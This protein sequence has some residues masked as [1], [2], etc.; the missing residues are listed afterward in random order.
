MD[1]RSAGQATGAA[2]GGLIVFL[3]IL[4]CIQIMKRERTSSLCVSALLLF[5]I[6]WMLS[7]V[8][9]TGMAVWSWSPMIIGLLGLLLAG[10]ALIGLILGI[11]GLVQYDRARYDQ[12]RKQAV[13]GI[14]LC[15]LMLIVFVGSALSGMMKARDRGIASLGVAKREEVPDKNFAITPPNGW[16]KIDHTVMGVAGAAAGF[17]HIAPEMYCV[18]L[19][20]EF[21]DGTPI[22]TFTKMVKQNMAIGGDVREQEENDRT[23]ND[24]QFH[25]IQSILRLKTMNMELYYEHWLATYRGMFWQVMV[26]GD[27]GQKDA[28]KVA[29]RELIDQFEVL[30]RNRRATALGT[31]EDV[32]LPLYGVKTQLAGKGWNKSSGDL[33][34][35]PLFRITAERLSEAFVVLPLRFEDESPELAAIAAGTLATMEFPYPLNGQAVEKPFSSSLGEGIEIETDRQ[36]DAGI[37]T[38]V[39]RVIRSEKSAFFVAGWVSKDTGDLQFLRQA[40]DGIELSE[41]AGDLPETSPQEKTALARIL[42]QAG[43]SCVSRQ[44][45]AG[46]TKWFRTASQ[47]NPADGQI[48]ANLSYMLQ[49]TGR[50]DEAFALLEKEHVRFP[51]SFDLQTQRALLLAA[52]GDLP[53]G[54][55]HFIELIGRGLTDERKLQEWVGTL[56]Q[57]QRGDLAEQ[58]VSK[59]NEKQATPLTQGLQLDV[60][61]GRGEMKR[62]LDLAEKLAVANE[63][64]HLLALKL[65]DLLNESGDHSR[66]EALAEKVLASKPED[67]DALQVL[68]W[69]QMGRKSYS[70]AKAT[71]E[72][73][74]KNNPQNEAIAIAIQRASSAL[75]QGQNSDVKQ[76]IDPVSLP[77]AVAKELEMPSVD[78][79]ETEGRPLLVLARSTGYRFEKGKP[80]RRTTRRSIKILNQTG[81][82]LM[83]NLEYPYDPVSERIFVNRLEVRDPEGKVTASG[84]VDDAFV[85]DLGGEIVSNRKILTV[86]VPGLH[87]GCV[88][89]VEVTTEDRAVFP[90]F[91]L[92]R[93]TFGYRAPCATEVV[94]VSGETG[95]LATSLKNGA[96][97]K[98]IKGPGLLAWS[99]KKIQAQADEPYTIP[100]EEQVTS[101]VISSRADNWASVGKQYLADIAD[102][103]Q[104]ETSIKELVAKLCAGAKNE[105]EKIELLSREVQKTI[106]YKAIEFGTRARTPNRAG[107]TLRYR[108]GDCKDHAVLLHQLLQE[109]GIVSHLALVNTSERVLPDIPTL[110]QFNHMVAHVPSLG[111]KWLVDPTSKY[112]PLTALQMLTLRDTHVLIVD[113][114]GS[115]LVPFSFEPPKGTA[116]IQSRRTL[117]PAGKDWQVTEDITFTGYYGMM[118]RGTYDEL[119]PAEQARHAQA[120]LAGDGAAEVKEFRFENLDDIS[121]PARIKMTYVV[122]D[123]VKSVNGKST[124]SLPALWER[125]YI[126]MGYLPERKTPFEWRFPFRLKSEVTLNLPKGASLQHLAKQGSSKGVE[127]TMKTS[128][129]GQPTANF[130]F[131][132]QPG[133]WAAREYEEI[134]AGWTAARRAWDGSVE[135]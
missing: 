17:R 33:T 50:E 122:R 26:W 8:F 84:S 24:V 114:K 119:T 86:P 21:G 83:S 18:V 125:N 6:C 121:Q 85:R 71:F 97:V 65:G 51:K 5:L 94:Y 55:G 68:G 59:W 106:G 47:L 103:L 43:L 36:T 30:D 39:L 102:R 117:T 129:S 54:H 9:S 99:V 109:A 73:A 111:E 46:A 66:A 133:R 60:I 78:G 87:P 28:L 74:A 98:V 96:G 88:I 82:N 2:L 92:A 53:A 135:W 31:F 35:N 75:G 69:S 3:G 23:I 10:A 15:T 41:P 27:V 81:V 105:R 70:L 62:A 108:Y 130:E 12:G 40:L 32:N 48:V 67:V 19:A 91:N 127:W 61:A 29:S 112:L 79:L 132:T 14:V 57:A 134:Y 38:Y 22:E 128:G 11:V 4:K 80:M 63:S 42:N 37:F 56:M 107:D 44:N 52:R 76:P 101:I 13:W 45:D 126:N 93:H 118:I 131:E 89:D 113:P 120:I 25:H 95:K 58:A 110:D 49:R 124:A 72:K 64:N 100:A 20:Q 90:E 123:A 7:S 16:Q 116:D 34:S 104:P 1:A 115:R 77:K